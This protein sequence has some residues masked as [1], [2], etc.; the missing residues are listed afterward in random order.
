M[1]PD[2]G[3]EISLSIAGRISMYLA[4]YDTCVVVIIVAAVP[5]QC[6]P[7]NVNAANPQY[8]TLHDP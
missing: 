3:I 7:R 5:R 8:S 6:C 2:P 4:T 1:N